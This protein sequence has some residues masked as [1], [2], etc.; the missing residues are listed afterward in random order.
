[1]GEVRLFEPPEPDAVIEMRSV[2]IHDGREYALADL[3]GATGAAI[4]RAAMIRDLKPATTTVA[5]CK[6]GFALADCLAQLSELEGRD[7]SVS[8]VMCWEQAA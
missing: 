3:A 4:L 8:E 2:I 5:R 1:M 7:V 6:N